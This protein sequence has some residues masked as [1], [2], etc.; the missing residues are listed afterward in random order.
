M[1]K[2]IL[3]DVDQT[4]V[5]A[6]AHHNVAYR[7]AFKEVF[8]VDAQLADI[9]FAGKI[10]PNIV[11][12]LAELKGIPKEVVESKLTEMIERI[13]SFFKESVDKGE[14]RVL[15]GVKELLE[16]LRKRNHFLGVV[17]GNPEDVT[18]S[19]LEK[20]KLKG[21][22]DIFV[23]GSEGKDRVELVGMAIAE[24]ERK[25]GT[26]FSGKDVVIVGDS[27]HDIE[28]GKPHGSLTIA[29]T[30]GFYPKEE[31]MKHSP[32]YLFQDLTDPK[33]LEVLQ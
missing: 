24:A 12:E 27:I 25:Y 8:R 10:I 28:C 18:Q 22:F 11:R 9:D 5:D 17:T 21:Y 1:S 3:F 7:K 14:I 23:Y 30:T 29:V 13:E 15:P 31:L 20:S 16:K 26:K 4:L 32:D 33:I 2:L 6:L 19:I